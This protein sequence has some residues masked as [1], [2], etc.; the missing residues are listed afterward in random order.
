MTFSKGHNASA[1]LTAEQVWQIRERYMAG[2]CTQASLCREYNVTIMTIGRIIRG[3]TWQGLAAPRRE[4]TQDD[5][6]ASMKRLLQM[7]GVKVEGNYEALV[8]KLNRTAEQSP[9]GQ[10]ARANRALDV[11]K[12]D[13]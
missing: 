9:V 2:G 3:E 13:T 4:P 5:I 7:P 11:L 8:E 12:S 1:K 6:E 10:E